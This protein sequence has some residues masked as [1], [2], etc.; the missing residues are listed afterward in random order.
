[1]L[2]PRLNVQTITNNK[3]QTTTSKTESSKEEKK[4]P[5]IMSSSVKNKRPLILSA[6]S[7]NSGSNLLLGP[8][9][10]VQTITNNKSQTTTSKTESLED[11]KKAPGNLDLNEKNTINNVLDKRT[12]K[13]KFELN[14]KINPKSNTKI[15]RNKNIVI[16]NMNKNNLF[17]INRDE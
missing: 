8:R 6:G 5:E 9:L 3:A 10:N 17:I 15:M 2:G 13:I 11:E 4:I 7:A 16:S 1:M 14:K 12:K